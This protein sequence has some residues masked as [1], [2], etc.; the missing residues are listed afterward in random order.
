MVVI[1][2]TSEDIYSG[3]E[4]EITDGVYEAVKV[5]TAAACERIARYAYEYARAHGR[6]RVDIVHKSNIMKKSDGLFLRSAQKV[7]ADYPDIET[8]EVIVDAL[9]SASPAGRPVRRPAL[10]RRFGDIVLTS[11]RA[12]PAAS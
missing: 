6:K 2:E 5:T 9:C 10:R 1:R 8:G 12:S 7:A 11:P 3:M 4:H